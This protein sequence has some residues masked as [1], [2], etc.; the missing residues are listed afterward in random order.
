MPSN[1]NIKIKVNDSSIIFA[2]LFAI[3]FIILKL[4]GTITWSWWWVL[5]PLWG[6]IALVLAAAV[7]GLVILCAGGAVLAL[8]NKVWE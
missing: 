4:T 1:K 8:C 7:V 6:P 3:V 2:G 5:C